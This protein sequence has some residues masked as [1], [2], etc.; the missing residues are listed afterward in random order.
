MQSILDL[1]RNSGCVDFIEQEGEDALEQVK[2]CQPEGFSFLDPAAIDVLLANYRERMNLIYEQVLAFEV[3]KKLEK[4]DPVGIMLGRM[5]PEPVQN[6][7]RELMEET[8]GAVKAHL[9]A[10]YP[11]LVGYQTQIRDHYI[12]CYCD[13][14]QAFLL[15]KEELSEKLLDGR[16]IH[17]I[18][19]LSTGGAD[20]HRNGRCVIGV[21][22]D[23]GTVYYKPHDCG[24]DAL[25]HEIVETWFADC[26][27]A[28]RVV[29]GTLKGQSPETDVRFA[30]VSCLK[31]EPVAREMD[32]AAY[33]Y[34]FG[35]L[36]ALFHGLGSNDMHMENII[37]CADRPAAVDVETILGTAVRKVEDSDSM[38]QLK[39]QQ[40]MADSLLRTCLL[41][42]RVYKGP[43]VS[44]MYTCREDEKCLPEFEGRFQ[45][46][47]G[48]ETEFI[49]G[50]REG[51]ERMLTHRD[52]ILT[53]IHAYQ[54]STVRC[55]LRNTSFYYLIRQML[56]Q[57]AYLSD[58]TSR[59]KV[60]QKLCSPFTAYGLEP[61]QETT[62]YEWNCLLKGDIPYYCTTIQGTNLCGEDPGQLVATDY[63]QTSV[64]QSAEHFLSRLSPEEE[65]FEEEL[66]R[67]M[68]THAPTDE[69][70]ENAPELLR[71]ETVSD[72]T[73]RE[74]I[75]G[76]FRQLKQDALHCTDGH[77]LWF[78]IA[79][80][81]EMIE[82]F[83]KV[84]ML[85][86][87]GMTAARIAAS[88]LFP[89]LQEEVA[90]LAAKMCLEITQVIDRIDKANIM[91]DK[92][93]RAI[94]AGLYTGLGCVI[95]ACHEM[96]L[97]G[98]SEVAGLVERLVHFALRYK[99]YRYEKQ[100]VAQGT[101]GL[102]L[103]LSALEKT[104]DVF[105]L[106]IAAA[107]KLLEGDLPDRADLPY[108]CAGI[109][110]ALA[111]AFAVSQDPRFQKGALAAFQ[112]VLDDYKPELNGWPDGTAKLKWL[113]DK[114]PH[115]AGIYLAA[116]Y[117]KEAL[118]ETL[119]N[120]ICSAALESML[121]GQT[122]LHLDSLDQGNG[123]TVL[124]LLKA[125]CS[126]RAEEVLS[127]MLKRKDQKGCFTV[128]PNGIR[129][130]FD[131]S[132]Y[133]GS[134]GIGYVLTK[135]L[136]SRNGLER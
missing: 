124:A 64:M 131:A 61:E 49:R 16:A 50:F 34:H 90:L 97:A 41:P 58:E 63:Y 29:E 44:P 135:V 56:F 13:F 78:S 62:M 39:S 71:D 42:V 123:L 89:E 107:E 23:A 36:A 116:S 8:K 65:G 52:E 68:F 19:H 83:G 43:L 105:E 14:L 98:I 111:A 32:L 129:S 108:G 82:S 45:T 120:K 119:L 74:E 59:N 20:I 100:N 57:P 48:Y 4:L 7:A 113:A 2:R 80:S 54:H 77:L 117:A 101:A 25:Y 15:K 9:H 21:K 6:A 128:T 79:E 136:Q 66:L 31:H 27:V 122:I 95:L 126:V 76:L 134:T 92:L 104:K 69:K 121:Q 11:L 133:M 93:A 96:E 22:T 18:L 40:E 110:A 114:G 38:E 37:S 24:L 84:A 60:Y 87:I 88:D 85:G 33:Y 26:T 103:A 72:E 35:I 53:L 67:I 51:Y 112:K 118:A 132:Y 91:E 86:N 70:P 99:L 125:G 115:E 12:D 94:P 55:L 10:A 46:V 81:L 30:F 102:V 75:T 28:A 109:G 3:R 5:N 1:L 127:T 73:L 47:E 17:R 106:T 130:S